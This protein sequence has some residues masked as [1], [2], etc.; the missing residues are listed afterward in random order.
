MRISS[1]SRFLTAL[2][3]L[4]RRLWRG[5]AQRS[6]T[7]TFVS[8]TDVVRCTPTK[9]QIIKIADSQ[10]PWLTLELA[11]EVAQRETGLKQLG[12]LVLTKDG[13]TVE[14]GTFEAEQL[15]DAQLE[16]DKVR[17]QLLS[18]VL[19]D[20]LQRA[21]TASAAPTPSRRGLVSRVGPWLG[22]A[23]VML[24]LAGMFGGPAQQ[25][26]SPQAQR[27][28]Q[29]VTGIGPTGALVDPAAPAAWN[30]LPDNY[31][32][33]LLAAAERAARGEGTG[34]PARDVAAVAAAGTDSTPVA[35]ANAASAPTGSR[36][37]EASLRRVRA[38]AQIR[39][40]EG[41]T[42]FYAFVDPMCIACQDLERHLGDVDR[43]YSVVAI[44][45]AFQT[46]ARD[47]A[48]AALCAKDKVAAW[49]KAAKAQPVGSK[50]CDDGYKQVDANNAMFL[51]LGFAATPT[52][53]APNAKVVQGTGEAVQISGWLKGNLK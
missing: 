19:P 16:F 46:G 17:D 47:L 11:F 30:D 34:L 27:L 9:L 2:Q 41:G 7:E 18:E 12:R 20:G 43:D 24:L 44:P 15:V 36:L 28:A 49:H 5:R 52:L 31:K 50:P 3:G 6:V 25:P 29:D 10:K 26:Q 38:G 1:A 21:R 45:V 48:A 32:R 14:L 42:P 51:S 33:V 8:T 35:L 22:G 40:R 53:V 13:S 39:M 37:T 23:V 4:A